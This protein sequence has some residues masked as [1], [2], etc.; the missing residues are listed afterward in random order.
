VHSI[1]RKNVT[2]GRMAKKQGVTITWL[3]HSA[4]HILTAK[5]SSILID[6]WLNNPKAPVNSDSI[7]QVDLILITHGHSDHMGNAEEVAA[8]T[9]AKLVAIYEIAKYFSLKGIENVQSLNKGGSMVFR[10]VRVTMVD[11]RH[12]SGIDLNNTVLPGGEAAGERAC[13]ISCR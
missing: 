1:L 4:F 8:K 12:S 13:S 2:E 3:G 6:P 7:T 5:G 11:A 9:G 10:D